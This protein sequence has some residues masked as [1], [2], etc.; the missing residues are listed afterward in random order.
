LR[1]QIFVAAI[2]WHYCRRQVKPKARGRG[3][4]W[5]SL[6]LVLGGLVSLPLA[7]SVTATGPHCHRVRG[8]CVTAGCASVTRR[9]GVLSLPQNQGASQPAKSLIRLAFT[10]SIMAHMRQTGPASRAMRPAHAAH[11]GSCIARPADRA[12]PGLRQR[13][14]GPICRAR[15]LARRVSP[16][17]IAPRIP[18]SMSGGVAGRPP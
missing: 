6:G 2:T 17:S 8:R 5:P 15:H 12:R 7:P 4:T 1:L 14:R 13:L 18:E 3:Y 9:R 10:F 16:A 11:A